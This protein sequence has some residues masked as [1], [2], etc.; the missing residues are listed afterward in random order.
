MK[1]ED[2]YVRVEKELKEIQHDIQVIRVAPTAPSSSKTVEFGDEPTQLRRLADATEAR[3]QKFQ[4]EKEQATKSLKKEKEEILE[5]LRV[6]WYCVTA[7]ENEKDE[8]R[9][10]LE[11]DKA[12]IQR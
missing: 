11:E 1:K 10:M 4:E 3:L 2:L 5:K 8:F 12:K 7:Y 6:A 9:V